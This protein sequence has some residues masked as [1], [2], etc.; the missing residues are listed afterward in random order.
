MS[1]LPLFGVRVLDFSRLLPGPFA[2]QILVDLGA[3]VIKIEDSQ[4]DYIRYS[5]PLAL[6]G[7]SALFHAINRG[8]KSI[9]LDLKNSS[10]KLVFAH[11]LKSS[12]VLIEGFRP[13][14]MEK[15]GFSPRQLL[16]DYPHLIVCSISGYGQDGILAMRAGHDINY[17]AQAGI[18]GLSDKPNIIP[19]Q[20]ADL[21]G[22]SLPAV[23]QILAALITRSKTGKGSLIDVSMCEN[24]YPLAVLSHAQRTINK[25]PINHG[26]G[27]LTSASLCYGFYPT[28]D[29]GLLAVGALES[30]YWISLCKALDCTDLIPLQH[31]A[32]AELDQAKLRLSSIF[33]SRTTSEWRN[34]FSTRDFM[35]EIVENP[36]EIHQNNKHFRERKVTVDVILD[37]NQNKLQSNKGRKAVISLGGK[38]VESSSL[39]SASHQVLS[40]PRMPLRMSGIEPIALRGPALGEHDKQIIDPIRSKL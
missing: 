25:A 14:I 30:P 3:E 20:V 40:L 13:G 38:A 22:G 5:P 26:T 9:Q 31:C 27:P 34:F 12:D 28:Q 8:K 37:E 11:L 18:L 21:A 23:I 4:G 6:D 29:G 35:V 39:S 33:L 1:S 24:C 10:D 36:E 17:L 16:L 32:G 19:I 2:S 7:N 15:L